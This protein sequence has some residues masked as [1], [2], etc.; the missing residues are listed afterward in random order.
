M[1][2]DV[3]DVLRAVT[4]MEQ[5][6]TTLLLVSVVVTAVGGRCP[7]PKD[8]TDLRRN[9]RNVTKSYTIY[10]N[11]SKSCIRV[12]CDMTTDSGGWTV[13]QRRISDSD[14]YR[15]WDE[16]RD[17]FG[18]LQDNFWLGN[19]IIS[20]ITSSGDYQLRVDLVDRNGRKAYA[21]Y[22]TFSVGGS[23]TNYKLRVW[24]YR[25]TA[26]DSLTYHNGRAFTTKDRDN[27]NSLEKNCA[28]KFLGAWWYRACHYSNLNGDYG[29]NVYGKGLNWRSW[30]GLFHSLK[31]TE[32]KIRRKTS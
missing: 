29:N 7:R 16:Y 12:R 20:T 15:T 21:I 14:F 22:D 26:G 19:E 32:L 25:G 17:G 2:N 10:P 28:R 5:S 18:N 24:N 9:G 27:D 3:G 8:C 13:I 23:N 11:G 4:R 30:R 31:S 1:S 6:L